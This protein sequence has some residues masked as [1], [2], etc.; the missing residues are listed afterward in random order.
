MN[1]R[2]RRGA[3]DVAFGA[4]VVLGDADRRARI[5]GADPT[6]QTR[7]QLDP[8][9]DPGLVDIVGIPQRASRTVAP[10]LHRR[11]GV[12][13]ELAALRVVVDGE[14]I[15]QTQTCGLIILPQ[16]IEQPGQ[17]VRA[18]VVAAVGQETPAVQAAV[19]LIVAAEEDSRSSP[20]LP[21]QRPAP[22]GRL[23]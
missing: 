16:L 13:A 1:V 19:L 8:V 21:A 3:V 7:D 23:F 2:L 17:V 9:V 4:P 20:T 5:V 6:L 12:V 10:Q 18:A 14:D 22:S 11:R 15:E